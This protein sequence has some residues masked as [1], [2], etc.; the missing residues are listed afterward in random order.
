MT[1]GRIDS[2]AWHRRLQL[3]PLI[4]LLLLYLMLQDTDMTDFCIPDHICI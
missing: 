2:A 4:M 3:L 1:V